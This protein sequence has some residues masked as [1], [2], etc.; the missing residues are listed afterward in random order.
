MDPKNPSNGQARRMVQNAPQIS[1]GHKFKCHFVT[2]MC[3]APKTKMKNPPICPTLCY[4]IVLPARK[5]SLRAGCW[6]DCYRESTD[7]GP[8]AGRK[9]D[10]VAFPVALRPNG[11]EAVL[12]NIEYPFASLETWTASRSYLFLLSSSTPAVEAITPSW[13]AY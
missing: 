12:R 9:P 6:P 10:F 8:S 2:I 3:S 1:P 11:P 5:S 4:A 7:I 13:A